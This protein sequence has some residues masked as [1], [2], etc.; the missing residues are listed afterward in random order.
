MSRSLPV[1][2]PL[3]P[4]EHDLFTAMP[5]KLMQTFLGTVLTLEVLQKTL[6]NRNVAV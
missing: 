4:S 5:V 6:N 3:Q 2:R 1:V